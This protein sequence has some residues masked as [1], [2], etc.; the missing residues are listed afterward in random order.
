MEV[1]TSLRKALGVAISAA[2]LLAFMPLGASMANADSV[3]DS[4]HIELE[5][6][7]TFTGASLTI[8]ASAN[9][10]IKGHKFAAVRLGTYDKAAKTTSAATAADYHMLTGLAIGTVDQ[11][12]TGSI[13]DAVDSAYKAVSGNNSLST[14]Y[15]G[16][17]VGQVAATMLGLT[18]TD[19]NADIAAQNTDTTSGNKPYTGALRKFAQK[20]GNNTDGSLNSKFADSAT[21]TATGASDGTSTT[22]SFSN[23][24]QGLYIIKDMSPA[25]TIPANSQLAIPMIVG[26]GVYATGDSTPYTRFSNNQ[27]GV[28]L[29]NVDVKDDVLSLTKT[30][31][32]SS[33]PDGQWGHFTLQ[34]TV[35]LTTGYAQYPFKIVDNPTKGY[36]V[37]TASD[38]DNAV[39]VYVKDSASTA[40]SSSNKLSADYYTATYTQSTDNAG[41]KIVVDFG[42]NLVEH[43]TAFPLGYTIEITY[44]LQKNAR[45]DSPSNTA[46]LIH[47]TV[48]G[49]TPCDPTTDPNC[50]TTGV[51]PSN[52]VKLHSFGFTI[53]N[54][55]R[56]QSTRLQGS[57]FTIAPLNADGTTGAKIN[58]T[59][60]N[61]VYSAVNGTD[62]TLKVADS[63]GDPGTITVTG[64]PLGTYDVVQTGAAS[65]PNLRGVMLPHFHVT[66]TASG[67]IAAD[68][69]ATAASVSVKQDAWG[70]VDGTVSNATVTVN[71][72][73]SVVQ[74]P[75]T[76]GMGII[77]A[78]AVVLVLA[79]A[80]GGTVVLKRRHE[81]TRRHA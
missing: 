9:S 77:L 56:G 22:V 10:Y 15:T 38:A 47:P 57:T 6:A 20:L 3:P 19:P 62:S 14:E 39:K 49:T 17:P 32:E 1:H 27:S 55:L 46:D 75:L 28:E 52:T 8:H 73:A 69:T 41:G 4:S 7:S 11:T 61:G 54:V 42:N 24:P 68:G 58:F 67:P 80:F 21:P 29:G 26:T 60:S 31:A 30:L 71:N 36:T 33:I 45:E 23:L 16:N 79:L 37:P 2:T 40:N 18:S 44:G 48:P 25:D 70:L 65:S 43:P 59:G 74:L 64:L 78:V 51:V 63:T 50:H 34:T 81:T 72:V 76:G 5:D 13:Y 66:L 53:K 12:G 35:P